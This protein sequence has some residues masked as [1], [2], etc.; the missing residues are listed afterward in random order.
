VTKRLETLRYQPLL[1]INVKYGGWISFF[2][3]QFIKLIKVAWTPIG[4]I[5]KVV[6]IKIEYFSLL[7]V[8]ANIPKKLPCVFTNSFQLVILKTA[9][10]LH[11][12]HNLLGIFIKRLPLSVHS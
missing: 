9:T 1:I 4:E 6:K 10:Y 7:I 11:H 8:M 12:I 3:T 2:V 5:F